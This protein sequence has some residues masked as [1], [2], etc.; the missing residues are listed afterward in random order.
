MLSVTWAFGPPRDE[1]PLPVML[2][3]AKHLLFVHLQKQILGRS[4]PQ[5]D[6]A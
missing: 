4:A 6:K 5:N 3:V 2:S 1:S